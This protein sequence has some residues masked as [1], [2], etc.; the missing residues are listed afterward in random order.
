MN[1]S[2]REM[3]YNTMFYCNK[4]ENFKKQWEVYEKSL[5]SAQF[6]CEPKMAIKLK[7]IFK[8]GRMTDKLWLVRLRYL[9]DIFS[10]INKVSFFTSRIA[11]DSI[12]GQQ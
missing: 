6:C 8:K 11:T 9:A 2:V 3:D 1:G 4:K 12:C 5:P 10:K 7:P